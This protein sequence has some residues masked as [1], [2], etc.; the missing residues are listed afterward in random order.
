[1]KRNILKGAFLAILMSVMLMVVG[2]G[3]PGYDE[4]KELVESNE[5]ITADAS[6]IQNDIANVSEN[7]N[8]GEELASAKEA[9]DDAKADISAKDAEISALKEQL[10]EASAKLE[11]AN[12]QLEAKTSELADTK[13]LL[14][15]AESMAEKEVEVINGEI[16]CDTEYFLERATV[17][18]S[19]NTAALQATTK[20]TPV[21]LD[22]RHADGEKN[23][24][25]DNIFSLPRNGYQ[26]AVTFDGKTVM[27]ADF[28]NYNWA[29]A[30]LFLRNNA[31]TGFKLVDTEKYGKLGDF[32]SV[33]QVVA[34]CVPNENSE[35]GYDFYVRA[36]NYDANPTITKPETKPEV[37]EKVVEVIKEVEKV[38]EKPVE[39]I[40][41]VEKVV[42]KPVEVIKEVEKVVT[43]TEYVDR[44][45]PVYITKPDDNKPGNNPD[46]TKPENNTPGNNPNPDNG[47]ADDI[48]T[49]DNNDNSVDS[50][51]GVADDLENEMEETTN[52]N[53]PS[54]NPIDT[55]DSGVAG[56]MS[57]NAGDGIA[58]DMQDDG[59]VNTS[60]SNPI[61]C[62]LSKESVDNGSSSPNPMATSST[63][64]AGDM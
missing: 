1:M 19:D 46:P 45:I 28:G 56:D 10:A 53:T 52:G 33:L 9:L 22:S 59:N 21:V 47:V 6:D 64:I 63:G 32:A 50:D 61:P 40:K 57:E 5:N 12:A 62:D 23:G 18:F 7:A 11:K 4:L 27:V 3:N 58:N 16:H 44:Y 31:K 26:I 37:I 24:Y 38:V 17:I 51:N 20:G 54:N 2:C 49:P 13:N 42:E 14:A 8:C 43:N 25:R 15:E 36:D 29:N 39:V 41:E 35:Y 48:E 30:G 55:T 34:V 60:A